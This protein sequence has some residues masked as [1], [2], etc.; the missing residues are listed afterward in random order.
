M[1][2]NPKGK[3]GGS[4]FGPHFDIP[5]MMLEPMHSMQVITPAIV[6]AMLHTFSLDTL[7]VAVLAAPTM[8]NRM[9]VKTMIAMAFIYSSEH[10]INVQAWLRGLKFLPLS[11]ISS[12]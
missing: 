11:Y 12:A 6:P 4:V 3:L 7:H 10:K 1:Q 5:R 9:N 8:L 2:L